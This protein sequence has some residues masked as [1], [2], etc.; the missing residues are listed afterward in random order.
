MSPCGVCR[1]PALARVTGHSAMT[2][3][4][5]A[6]E[7][8]DAVSTTNHLRVSPPEMIISFRRICFGARPECWIIKSGMGL[9]RRQ[10]LRL[11][12]IG[13]TRLQWSRTVAS[14]APVENAIDDNGYRLALPGYKYE[15]PR[16]H[17][18][19]PDF[20]TEWWYY[21]GNLWSRDGRRFGVELVFFRQAQQ[22]GEGSSKSAWVVRDLYLAH[23]ALTDAA[24]GRFHFEKRLNRGGPGIA[25]ASFEQRRVWN[26]NWSVEWEVD[27]GM[28]VLTAIAKDVS[29]RLALRPAKAPVIHG[30]NGVS[31]KAEGKGRASHYVSFTRLKAEGWIRASEQKSDVSGSF[32]MDHEWFTHQ[33]QPE[34]MG[35]DWFSLQ[36][37]DQREFMLFQLRRKDGSIDPYS[38]GTVVTSNGQSRR[39][40]NGDFSLKPLRWWSNPKSNGKYPV[41]WLIE[42]PSEGLRLTCRA[43]LD[44][45]ELV[46]RDAAGPTYWEGAVD[47]SG[48]AKGVG[49]LE[50]TGYD[51][52]VSL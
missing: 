2:S 48:S 22:R 26:G 17:F 15:F 39:L 42:V 14:G 1:T 6:L 28:Q 52:P 41:E 30:Q 12:T 3:K 18:S 19:H 24:N 7:A 34:Q 44:S 27:S 4:V 20:K 36:L 51:K 46:S 43:I 49:Y 33:L 9:S 50:M 38:S 35:W 13:L 10:I 31:Q 21:T 25:G 45:Q 29:F 8:G 23:C 11:G 32:W 5:T 40:T 47:Y 16:D 37:D